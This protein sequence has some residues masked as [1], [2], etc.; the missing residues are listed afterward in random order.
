MRIGR[1]GLLLG[2]LG[3]LLGGAVVAQSAFSITRAVY[4]ETQSPD[5]NG[6]ATRAIEPASTLQKGDRVILLVEW[7]AGSPGL[8]QK[9]RGYTVASEI[10]HHL[11]FQGSSNDAYQISTDGG[12]NWGRLGE[13]HV[14]ERDGARLVS[15]EDV[16]NVRW[17]IAR[18]R[19]VS[20]RGRI[21]YSAIVR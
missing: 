9:I 10:P 11:A 5:H 2:S 3:C 14:S 6:S 21:A 18:S 1:L 19:L 4:V 8:E 13:M 12:R 16:T 20:G 7:E 15:P 17:T